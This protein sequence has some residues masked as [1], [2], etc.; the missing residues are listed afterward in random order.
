M[1]AGQEAER[2]AARQVATLRAIHAPDA[3]VARALSLQARAAFDQQ[4]YRESETLSRQ[5]VALA[6]GDAALRLHAGLQAAAGLEKLGRV[7]DADSELGGI[8]SAL[9]RAASAPSTDR[10][11]AW[12]LRARLLYV[13]NRSD[14]ATRAYE[15]G[16]AEALAAEG[17]L[18]RTAID[19]R[20]AL[21]WN[22]LRHGHEAESR[23]PREAV[24]AALRKRGGADEIRAALVE[25]DFA[26]F[27]ARGGW[28]PFEQARAL[29]EG[30][31]RFLAEAGPMVPAS[32][33]ATVDLYL[34]LM[35]G[36]W[37]DVGE[38][39]RLVESAAARLHPP[40]DALMPRRGLAMIRGIVAMSA[41]QHALADEQLRQGRDLLGQMGQGQ[42]PSAA[43]DGIRIA[44][45]LGM[46][47]RHAE[48]LAAIDGMPAS[49]VDRSEPGSK[50]QYDQTADV[51]RARFLLAAGNPA[52][53][54]QRL[55]PLDARSGR[56]ES[57]AQ[58]TGEMVRGEALCALKERAQGL[59]RL[60]AVVDLYAPDSAPINPWI[61]RTR[62]VAGLC[63]LSAGRAVLA[64]Q[65][66]RQ[67]HA[68]LSAQPG[69]SPYF[70]APL[71]Q[72]ERA[73]SERR[74]G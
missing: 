36:Q 62:A 7:A 68:A 47:G 42:T 58:D 2:Y 23:A 61:A 34:G 40:A 24:L 63:A 29:V 8:E 31:R 22:L 71:V 20:L 4:L 60:Q 19:I 44:W 53:A 54:L 25:S 59:A 52:A 69:V 13:G 11:L 33:A 1:G 48:A 32:I 49:G 74:G 70:R 50:R 55:P 6:A 38:A 5:A 10:A 72:L 56:H 64:R 67:A 57:L 16:V 12:N 51:A 26:S 27:L 35:C 3:D 65:M 37:G 46:Q 15:A 41:G 17:P 21:A 30:D 9:G 39:S 66:A 28:V 43:A 73:L 45:N 18:S 14:A